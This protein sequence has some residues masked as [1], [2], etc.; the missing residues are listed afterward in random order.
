MTVR[1]VYIF[2][3]LGPL[4]PEADCEEP[5]AEVCEDIRYARRVRRAPLITERPRP[6]FARERRAEAIAEMD[7]DDEAVIA[8]DDEAILTR[9]AFG[10]LGN[11]G[12]A[13]VV[14]GLLIVLASWTGPSWGWGGIPAG[15]APDAYGFAPQHVAYVDQGGEPGAPYARYALPAFD[16]DPP[17]FVDPSRAMLAGGLLLLVGVVLVAARG[18]SFLRF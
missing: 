11:V 17:P 7:I 2:Q 6:R 8:S 10:G 16:D 5:E 14:I 13:L 18:R 12:A 1:D 3:D 9:A 15:R 4:E